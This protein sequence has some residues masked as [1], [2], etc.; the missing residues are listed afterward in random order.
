MR[1]GADAAMR[2]APGFDLDAVLAP[3]DENIMPEPDALARQRTDATLADLDESEQGLREPGAADFFT[4]A[5]GT[6]MNFDDIAT[7]H[8]FALP[9]WQE[10]GCRAA[11]SGRRQGQWSGRRPSKP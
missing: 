1:S 9:H 11:D 3:Q 8:R 2:L 5:C 4:P 7:A 10:R 6:E